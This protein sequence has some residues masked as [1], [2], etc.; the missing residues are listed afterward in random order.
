[1][2]RYPSV[3]WRLASRVM[4]SI[5]CPCAPLADYFPPTRRT[6]NLRSVLHQIRRVE[7]YKDPA[8]IPF[9][10]DRDFQEGDRLGCARQT[11]PS[12]LTTQSGDPP[13]S[14]L[15]RVEVV[16][17]PDCWTWFSCPRCCVSLSTLVSCRVSDPSHFLSFRLNPIHSRHYRSFYTVSR[18]GETS[19]YWMGKRAW[20]TRD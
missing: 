3:S 20:G 9:S 13:R 17:T 2:H 4:D 19:G 12:P 14:L 5:L 15:R 11:V 7:V 18:V 8:T 16:L 6:C 1:M 10:L